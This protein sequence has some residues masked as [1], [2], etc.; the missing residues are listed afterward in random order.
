MKVHNLEPLIEKEQVKIVIFDLIEDDDYHTL[1][2]TNRDYESSLR[3]QHDNLAF[4][5]ELQS[6]DIRYDGD[7]WACFQ[8]GVTR[9]EIKDELESRGYL[10]V[11]GEDY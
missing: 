10:V 11:M 7:E 4:E 6:L 5:R 8:D 9:D 1:L 3:I 2:I